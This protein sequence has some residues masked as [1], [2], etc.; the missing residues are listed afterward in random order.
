MTSRYDGLIT[1]I[2]LPKGLDYR[3]EFLHHPYVAQMID[4]LIYDLD[5]TILEHYGSK[6]KP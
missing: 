2:T 6:I 1:Q 5:K 3:A 4:C